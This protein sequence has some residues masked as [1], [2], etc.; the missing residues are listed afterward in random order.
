MHKA[1]QIH[2]E[3]YLDGK[4]LPATRCE[5]ESHLNACPSCKR[6]VAEVR[7][8]HQWMQLLVAESAAADLAPAPGFYARV[9]ARVEAEQASRVSIWGTLF[10]VFSRQLRVAAV[11]LALILMGFLITISQTEKPAPQLTADE[12]IMEAPAIRAETPALTAD[13]HSNRENVMRAIV[14][15]VSSVEGD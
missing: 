12:M 3:G 5:V 10:P 11:A 7:E 13:T 8:T 2:I 14:A 15:P 4:L 1:V 9:C 6:E